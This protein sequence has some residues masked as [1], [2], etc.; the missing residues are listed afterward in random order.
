MKLQSVLG[1]GDAGLLRSAVR[2]RARCLPSLLH[3][4][5]TA[6]IGR[7]PKKPELLLQ[8]DKRGAPPRTL[9]CGVLGVLPTQVPVL[10]DTLRAD[11]ADVLHGV[12]KHDMAEAIEHVVCGIGEVKDD[13]QEAFLAR[14]TGRTGALGGAAFKV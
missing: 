10:G 5:R 3:N 2:I 1:L 4:P 7:R 12:A 9:T 11:T 8:H 13:L 14:D 6:T